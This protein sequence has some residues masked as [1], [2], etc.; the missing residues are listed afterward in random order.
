MDGSHLVEMRWLAPRA[1]SGKPKMFL[2]FAP[3]IG[4]TDVLDPMGGPKADFA[5]ALSLIEA[6]CKGLLAELA[7]PAKKAI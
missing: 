3:P 5:L 2:S 1:L 7:P 4:V 6:G